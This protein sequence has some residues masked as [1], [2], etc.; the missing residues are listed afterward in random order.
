L[1]AQQA[2]QPV[3]CVSQLRNYASTKSVSGYF[4]ASS[5]GIRRLEC[6]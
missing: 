6:Q 5:A 3:N 1:F 4:E 2:C